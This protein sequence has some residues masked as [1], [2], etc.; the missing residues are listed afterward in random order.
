MALKMKELVKLSETPKS[1]ILYYIR[2]GLLPQPEKP[3]PNV[4]L[5]DESFVERIRFIKYLQRNF[6]AS[7]G[8]IK[9]LMQRK[10][11]DFKRGYKSVLET[12][13]LLMA[14]D[15]SRRYTSEDLCKKADIDCEKLHHYI[16][17][18]VIFDRENGFSE[19]ELEIIKILKELDA[20]D[21][22]GELLQAYIAHARSVARSEV[23]LTQRLIEYSFDTDR[24]EKALFDA[25]LI[26]KPYLFNMILMET[27]RK[28]FGN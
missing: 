13:D 2:E 8:E 21:P 25:T 5:Y 4:H 3:K 28:R 1:T 18:N 17:N 14:P 9:D 16:L 27:Y 26:L 19:K 23:D 24:T 20:V 22:E 11:F 15:S 6:G 12:L 7:I 10:D